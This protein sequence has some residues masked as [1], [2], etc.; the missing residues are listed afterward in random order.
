MWRT[1]DGTVHTVRLQDVG[2][3]F[4]ERSL[5][6]LYEL[7]LS[8]PGAS[9]REMLQDLLDQ[10]YEA[11]AGAC[12]VES[13]ERMFV[14][15]VPPPKI[16]ADRVSDVAGLAAVLGRVDGRWRLDVLMAVGYLLAAISP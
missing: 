13:E 1:A 7:F 2:W 14:G 11:H 6:D 10:E 12:V 8:V 15:K 4:D 16:V 3:L 5:Q 9:I